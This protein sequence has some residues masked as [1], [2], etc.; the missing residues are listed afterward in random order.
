MRSN[1]LEILKVR[2]KPV[3]SYD[4]DSVMSETAVLNR[5][6][7][8]EKL[9]LVF[10][11]VKPPTWVLCQSVT[12]HIEQSEYSTFQILRHLVYGRRKITP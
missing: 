1:T 6:D 4:K 5:R 8:V 11:S 10:T 12:A 2:V 3:F 7:D 9:T